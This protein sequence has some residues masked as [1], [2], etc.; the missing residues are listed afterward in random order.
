MRRKTKILIIIVLPL[1]I[2]LTAV[3]SYVF[4]G[5]GVG[6]GYRAREYQ[7]RPLECFDTEL[8][9][10]LERAFGVSFPD[11]ITEI[12][13]A[14]ATIATEGGDICFAMK[15][16]APPSVVD[17]F[18]RSIP[19][20]SRFKEYNLSEDRRGKLNLFVPKWFTEPIRVGKMDDE[21]IVSNHIDWGMCIDTSDDKNYVVYW[22]GYYALWDILTQK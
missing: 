13:T 10:V 11:G 17:A 7:F 4:V 9:A 14:K 22:G 5:V 21:R 15:F 2:L 16:T 6:M 1:G 20:T 19:W 3:G 18:I 8:M 12:K